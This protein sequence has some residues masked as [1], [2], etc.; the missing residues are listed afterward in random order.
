MRRIS[1][2]LFSILSVLGITFG[3]VDFEKL[4]ISLSILRIDDEGSDLTK[5][6]T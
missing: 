2:A 5:K 1:D 3:K 4:G 6:E